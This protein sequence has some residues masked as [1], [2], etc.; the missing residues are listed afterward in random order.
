MLNG[1][2]LVVNK[3]ISLKKVDMKMSLRIKHYVR[4]KLGVEIP[5]TILV[6]LQK[7]IDTDKEVC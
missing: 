3:F 4:I 7:K 6:I 1:W 5:L 2:C